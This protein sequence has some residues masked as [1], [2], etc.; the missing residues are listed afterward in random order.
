M[1]GTKF[2][3]QIGHFEHLTPH[4]GQITAN[5][6][7]E[8]LDNR[9][10]K[11]SSRKSLEECFEEARNRFRTRVEPVIKK[12][13]KRSSALDAFLAGS[14]LQTLETACQDLNNKAENKSNNNAS[15]L[16]TT[17]D[18]LKSVGDVFLEFAPESVSI[19]WFGISTLISIGN[20]K[21]QTLLLICGACDSITNIIADC[22]RWEARMAVKPIG[23]DD[24]TPKLDIWE[25]E[26]PGL[27]LSV[28][29]FLWSA[30]PHLEDRLGSSLKDYFTKELQQKINALL[31]KYQEIVKLAQAHFE[32]SVFHE[33]MKT[34]LK[35]DQLIEN[36]NKYVLV[37][38]DLVDAVQKQA[39][40]YELDRQ[41]SQLSIS[42]SHNSH[43]TSLNERFDQIIKDRDG[44]PVSQWLFEE[45]AYIDWKTGSTT[46]LCIKAPRGYGK[47]VAMMSVHRNIR[48]T[49]YSLPP[50][51]SRTKS[52]GLSETSAVQTPAQTQEA[53]FVC[54]FFFKK[55]EQDIQKART[56]LES[57]LYQLLSSNFL[58]RSTPA[59]VA[60]IGVLNPEFGE[61]SGTMGKGTGFLE[62]LTAL[63]HAIK[64]VAEAIS[65]PVYIMID[66]LDECQDRREQELPQLI[67]SLAKPTG[68]SCGLKVIISARD[69][70][71]IIK[72]LVP[73]VDSSSIQIPDQLP[74]E[75]KVIEITATKNWSDLDK[76]LTHDVSDV[77]ERRID[78]SEGELFVTI[79]KKEISRIVKIIH[80]KANGDFTLARMILKSLQ[81]PSKYSLEK[82]I[83]QLPAAIGDIYMA[84]LEAL[85]PDEQELIVTA[86][87]WVVWSV[88]SIT[89]L[90]ISDHYRD[91]YK[92]QDDES[93]ESSHHSEL[94]TLIGDNPY[95]DPEVKDVLHHLENAGRD[96]FKLD[97]H[98]NF[99]NV[100]IS[101]REWIQSGAE[102]SVSTTK[103]SRGF[104][105]FREN[106]G[107]TVFQFRLTPSF[108]KYGDTLSELFNER[109]AHM[110]IAI[111]ILRAL[112]S[113]TFQDKYLP[114]DSL[115]VDNTFNPPWRSRYEVF[116][117]QDHLRILQKWWTPDSLKDT[118]W[119]DLLTQ[120]TIFLRPENWYRCMA[121][122]NHSFET[123]YPAPLATFCRLFQQPIHVA[124]EFGLNM[125]IDLLSN[126]TETW[127]RQIEETH[128]RK[129]D[130]I[131]DLRSAR[132]RGII[133]IHNPNTPRIDRGMN[134]TLDC[135]EFV[136]LL[137]YL[138]KRYIDPKKIKKYFSMVAA[139]K[140]PLRVAWLADR[141][142]K[143]TEEA[144]TVALK[145]LHQ[146]ASEEGLDLKKDIEDFLQAYSSK[147]D[148]VGEKLTMLA[149][150]HP[151]FEI[152]LYSISESDLS[153]SIN[154]IYLDNYYVALCDRPDIF[155]RLPLDRAKK[156]P[157]TTFKRLINLGANIEK[158]SISFK[159]IKIQTPL[160]RLLSELTQISFPAEEYRQVVESAI[161]LISEG[162]D[163]NIPLLLHY[164]AGSQD[165]KLFKLL[166]MSGDWNVHESDKFGKTPL[167]YLF[168]RQSSNEHDVLQICRLLVNMKRHDGGD[169]V[170][171]ED[172]DSKNAL[173]YAVEAGFVEGVRLLTQLGADIHDKDNKGRN[174]FHVLAKNHI[175]NAVEIA[176]LL[177]DSGV[178]C[179]V[180]DSNGFTPL[181]FALKKRGNEELVDLLISKYT[182]IGH[183]SPSQNPLLFRDNKGNTVLH[184]AIEAV[185]P[186]KT[187]RRLLDAVSIFV[188]IKTFVSEQNYNDNA[189][190]LHI[191][192]SYCNLEKVKLLTDIN[193]NITL[194]S[195]SGENVLEELC[196]RI[197]EA[198]SMKQE[199]S[200]QIAVFN[201][202]LDTAFTTNYPPFEFL[203]T[204]LF[205]P[206]VFEIQEDIKEFDLKRIPTLWDN[207]FTDNHGWRLVDF[208]T[209]YG[210]REDLLTLLPDQK[211]SPPE[212]FMLPSRISCMIRGSQKIL[213]KDGLS[214]SA[215][216]DTYEPE[217]EKISLFETTMV[218]DHPLP[219][220]N[221]WFYFEIALPRFSNPKAPLPDYYSRC[222]LGIRMMVHRTGSTD[223]IWSLFYEP[224]HYFIAQLDGPI[225]TKTY[226]ENVR[227]G[228]VLGCGVNPAER[229]VFF[230]LDG[231]AMG[232][233]SG[234]SIGPGRYFPAVTVF[235]HNSHDGFKL[236]FGAEP[237]K[238]TEAN[239]PGWEWKV[240][241]I[242]NKK[243]QEDNSLVRS[244]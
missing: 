44:H 5:M 212:N 143:K 97:A 224:A 62:N 180:K 217:W 4:S 120:L 153:K 66:A 36:L 74:A 164:A 98:T 218:A 69:S 73:N 32:E 95:K 172:K 184:S 50:N 191:E 49:F 93:P 177:F 239:K 139:M 187:L 156:Y 10:K 202:L 132:V 159:G 141:E 136:E 77:L 200:H 190:A 167:H 160:L 111:N 170:N 19:V 57:V 9:A 178:D 7:A 11:A 154:S 192:L 146:H 91:M 25:T 225:Q 234:F 181:S 53:P 87:K 188:D 157:S 113:T 59:L 176:N 163:L 144:E 140:S 168:T 114:F 85:A 16:L 122:G 210:G 222:G 64:T 130:R 116:H 103:E 211:S 244:L 118:W 161:M 155:G 51:F 17:L 90:E 207:S 173:A 29:D 31:E 33:N 26:I 215:S 92:E 22:V 197:Y 179:T 101:V 150:H 99:V 183:C 18:S 38:H 238:F 13:P 52:G 221:K 216:A 198:W 35:V 81:Q 3:K 30:K 232:G 107:T 67:R 162:A 63:C 115:E 149:S 128:P 175:Q 43:F 94:E 223:S 137:N 108:V 109:E 203:G 46:L 100:D 112:N 15:K 145:D 123:E 229:L 152:S 235:T 75:L 28:L 121:R 206:K 1:L 219:P 133:S 61:E 86:L 72:E 208:L 169:L 193:S 213:P 236:N 165:L 185:A 45:D 23:A 58:R 84:S 243:N 125:I 142:L 34:G 110:Y 65:N 105:R 39:L 21:V 166:C 147:E 201:H 186:A 227:D 60:T 119:S 80:E 83:R 231:E 79:Y 205:G 48:N 42:N 14:S 237:F 194:P 117:W 55:G 158:K 171:V 148:A 127:N 89:F 88:S 220:I 214:F 124:C 106:D 196:G 240:E 126:A 104:N 228:S 195:R 129:I 12:D 2:E 20:A 226:F 82:R 56:A 76:Y 151:R 230:T 70:I 242:M 8:I 241:S 6:D 209:A 27:I 37:G 131:R 40:L 199:V 54:H 24:D 189:T 102:S 68:D 41:S 134:L 182:E 204:S 71:D 135:E 174:C 78:Q 233:Q 138:F 96:F 47:S